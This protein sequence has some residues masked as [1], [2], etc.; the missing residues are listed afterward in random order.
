MAKTKIIIGNKEKHVLEIEASKFEGVKATVDGQTIFESH[1]ISE[2][3]KSIKL[4]IGKHEQHFIE[5]KVDYNAFPNIELTVDGIKQ[6]IEF[7]DGEKYV[8]KKI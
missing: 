7:S 2:S 6:N 5:I 4:K 1:A 8:D 3:A